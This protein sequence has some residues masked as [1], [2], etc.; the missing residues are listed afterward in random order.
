MRQAVTASVS[1]AHIRSLLA[2]LGDER[3]HKAPIGV[4]RR[5]TGAAPRPNRPTKPRARTLGSFRPRRLCRLCALRAQPPASLGTMPLEGIACTCLAIPDRSPSSSYSFCAS[6]CPVASIIIL[7]AAR[8]AVLAPPPRPVDGSARRRA[9]RARSAP[10]R[11]YPFFR[12]ERG[13]KVRVA[14]RTVFSPA[15]RDRPARRRTDPSYPA[16][17][18]PDQ[19]TNSYRSGLSR[20]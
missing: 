12:S 2:S 5:A 10:E 7:R 16:F 3:D 6:A 17:R 19:V 14:G 8:G 1:P 18:S 9:G 13:P 15:E 4:R 11:T 20:R